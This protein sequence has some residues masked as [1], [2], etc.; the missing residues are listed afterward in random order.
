MAWDSV[1]HVLQK[2]FTKRNHVSRSIY[3]AQFAKIQEQVKKLESACAEFEEGSWVL[4]HQSVVKE[5]Y[6]HW[7]MVILMCEFEH[8]IL[9]Y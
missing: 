6:T 5:T 7:Q 2:Y 1:F 4:E 8:A 9:L 3:D